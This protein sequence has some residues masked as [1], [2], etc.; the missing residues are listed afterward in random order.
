MNKYARSHYMKLPF[1]CFV[2]SNECRFFNV[3]STS[4]LN[5]PN[6]NYRLNNI[7][8]L[9]ILFLFV[10]SIFDSS[11]PQ[12]NKVLFTNLHRYSFLLVF[13]LKTLSCSNITIFM[14][15]LCLI[16]TVYIL[17]DVWDLYPLFILGKH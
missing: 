14:C 2:H 11:N 1:N 13:H 17:T 12:S 16:Y 5:K 4:S 9:S 6:N 10:F 3:F 15:F 7:Q 8:Q